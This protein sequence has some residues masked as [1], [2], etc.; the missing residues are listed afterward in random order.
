[1]FFS[2]LIFFFLFQFFVLKQMKCPFGAHGLMTLQGWGE[3]ALLSSCPSVEE[4]T[5][6]PPPDTSWREMPPLHPRAPIE[7]AAAAI[8]RIGSG[9]T[10]VGLNLVGILP[11]WFRCS[12]WTWRRTVLFRVKVRGQYGQETRMPLVN[13]INILGTNFAQIFFQQKISKPNCK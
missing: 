10:R 12:R 4:I 2:F 6:L 3:S 11:G 7:A 9:K 5:P 8:L 13:F 1:M